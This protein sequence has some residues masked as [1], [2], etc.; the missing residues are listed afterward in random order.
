MTNTMTNLQVKLIKTKD[1]LLAQCPDNPEIIVTGKNKSEITK[2]I[3]EI[4]S[5]YI[6]AFPEMKSNLPGNGVDFKIVFQ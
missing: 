4:M 2:N 3:H 5:G 1:G 6:E